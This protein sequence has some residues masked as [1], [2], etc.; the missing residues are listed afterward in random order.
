MKKFKLHNKICFWLIFSLLSLGAIFSLS[1]YFYLI[2]ENINVNNLSE[3]QKDFFNNFTNQD[4]KP[5]QIVFYSWNLITPF[6]KWVPPSNLLETNV[7]SW[8]MMPMASVFIYFILPMKKSWNREYDHTFV[9]S[10]YW[11][12]LLIFFFILCFWQFLMYL[13]EDFYE[14]IFKKTLE[15]KIDKNFLA[16][17]LGVEELERQT[18]IVVAELKIILKAKID[19]LIL[20]S[21]IFLGLGITTWFYATMFNLIFAKKI[22]NKDWENNCLKNSVDNS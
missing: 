15:R 4:G 3:V 12:S 8:L 10:I 21:T 2:G 19:A 7:C 6:N 1:T 17:N 18:Q 5:I 14:M 22:I 11:F 9:K 20:T 13:N 16:E